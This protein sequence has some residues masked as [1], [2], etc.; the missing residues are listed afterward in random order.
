MTPNKP[1]SNKP[2][3]ENDMNNYIQEVQNAL[4][5]EL[6]M[7]G[8]PYEGLLEVYGLLVFTVGVNCT[9]KHIHDAWS[10]WR[11]DLSHK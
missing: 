2:K 10:I 1:D 5:G 6:K 3:K 7:R 8:T 9:K 4:D 11:L